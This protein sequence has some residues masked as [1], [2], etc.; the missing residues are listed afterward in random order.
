[1]R[2][3]LSRF[4]L[5]EHVGTILQAAVDTAMERYGAAKSEF[6]RVCSTPTGGAPQKIREAAAAISQSLTREEMIS[7]MV[8]LNEFVED[9]TVPVEL[10]YLTFCLTNSGLAFARGEAD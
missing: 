3:R 8:R 10:K 5:S 7:A 9:G 6:W 2:Q 4:Y 1:M